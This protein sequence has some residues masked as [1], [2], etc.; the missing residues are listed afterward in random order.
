MTR[1]VEWVMAT[2]LLPHCGDPGHLCAVRMCTGNIVKSTI[3]QTIKN[4]KQ[5]KVLYT[6]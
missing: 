5:N 2:P 1:W 4:L 6:V 3:E